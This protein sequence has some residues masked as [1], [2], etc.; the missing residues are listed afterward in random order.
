MESRIP[1]GEVKVMGMA[2]A[3]SAAHCIFDILFEDMTSRNVEVLRLSREGFTNICGDVELGFS[4]FLVTA[5]GP[6]LV[7][8]SGKVYRVSTVKAQELR[9]SLAGAGWKLVK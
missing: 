7:D 9:K 1:V 2:T 4:F 5:S 6:T 3:M 8:L